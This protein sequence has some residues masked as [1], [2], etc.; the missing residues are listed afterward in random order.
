M[1]T[2][3]G[4]R[5]TITP[6]D[7]GFAPDLGDAF[8]AAREAG[9]LPNL[10]G[11]V[12]MR[13]GRIFFERY[14]AGTDAGLGR[15]LGIVRFGPD[16]LHD[17]RSVTKSIV[18]LLY[19][20]ALASGLVPA[21]EVALL[22]VFPEH[23]DLAEEPGRRLLTVRHALSMTLGTQWDEFTVPY[24]DPRNGETAMNAAPDRCRYVLERPIIAPP[25]QTWTYNGGTTAVLARL[26]AKGTKRSLEEFA[27]EALFAPLGIT[28]FEWRRGADS[29]AIAASGLRMAPRDLIRIGA[30]VLGGG[31]FN[32]SQIVPPEWLTASLTP[33]VALPDGRRYGYQWYLGDVVMDDGSGD[34][35]REPLISAM[36]N[37]GQ[38]LY[39]LPRL[40][41]VVAIT[42]GNYDAVGQDRP[43]LVI[44]RDVL[45]PALQDRSPV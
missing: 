12:A 3:E 23:R 10:H 17:L 42:A 32:E 16:T 8:A 43:P 2:R 1:V 30:M 13:R 36:G 34:L 40:D 6:A 5:E 37:G 24:G 28:K 21:P 45:L 27:H 39:L 44:L 26:I 22:D 9:I 41:L 20:I 29:E 35:R 38:R 11:V 4:S 7:A 31:C 14:L 15:P 19:G 33:S 25:G 18:G